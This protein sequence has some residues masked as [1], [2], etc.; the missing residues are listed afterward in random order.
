MR[1]Y[2]KQQ[3][4]SFRDRFTVKD[5]NGYDRYSVDGDIFSFPKTLHIYRASGEEVLTIQRK[6]FTFL[7][8]YQ[9]YRG[10][11][12][13]AEIVKE[14]TFFTPSYHI[15]GTPF[16]VEGDF[17][18]HH[19]EV[20]RGGVPVAE[21]SKEWFT[22]GDSYQISAGDSEDELMMLAIL[23]VIDCVMAANND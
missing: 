18:N 10:D 4:F 6:L 22:W 13:A 16:S 2:V 15:E 23:I 11:T 20:L 14:F 8:R 9:I 12:L 5:K 17:M 19:Y 1:L 3:V 21:I 7:P